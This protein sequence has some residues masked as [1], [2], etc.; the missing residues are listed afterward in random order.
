MNIN[1]LPMIWKYR[2]DWFSGG[3]YVLV[4][5]GL[6]RILIR[7]MSY[8]LYVVGEVFWEQVYAPRLADVTSPA[9]VLDLGANIGLFSLWAA[10]RWQ[11]R[12][13]PSRRGRPGTQSDSPVRL[14]GPGAGSPG[15][16]SP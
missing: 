8:D 16:R 11:P 12:A 14:S 9:V 3:R 4:D 15:G 5:V 2:R 13:R 7:P 10:R 1:Y 6:D